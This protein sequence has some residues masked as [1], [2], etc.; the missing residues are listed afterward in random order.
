MRPSRST[1]TSEMSV[2]AER[3]GAVDPARPVPGP[4]A[5]LAD[6]PVPGRAVGRDRDVVHPVAAAV[7][8]RGPAPSRRTS[9]A[10][11][12]RSDPHPVLVIDLQR[13]HLAPRRPRAVRSRWSTPSTTCRRTGHA[14]ANGLDI[15]QR[16][17]EIARRCPSRSRGPTF[18]GQGA[19]AGS[20]PCGPC[21]S[22]G[23]QA[24]RARHPGLAVG[25]ERQAAHL[26][27]RRLAV[28]V[29]PLAPRSSASS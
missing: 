8:E 11:D 15:G 6:E 24:D 23:Q 17:P 2:S 3:I 1:V 9:P 5:R 22:S 19:F 21:P 10:L 20:R 25:V 16:N 26:V 27:R 28:D 18:V 14:A 4:N 12:R 13:R 29:G 7:P